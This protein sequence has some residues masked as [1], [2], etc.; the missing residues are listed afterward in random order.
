MYFW[1]LV[2]ISPW[3]RASP[4]ICINLNYLYWRLLCAMFGWNWHVGS[5]EE[6]ENVK[7]LQQRQQQWQRQQQQ[8]RTTNKFWSE[9]LTWAFGL[10][11]LKITVQTT[12][13]HCTFYEKNHFFCFLDFLSGFCTVCLTVCVLGDS[14]GALKLTLE[15]FWDRALPRIPLA[16]FSP[17]FLLDSACDEWGSGLDFL[18]S[19]SCKFSSHSGLR[20]LTMAQ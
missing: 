12:F 19:L 8:R 7:S 5:G 18:M 20:L 4:F 9:N 3:K 10:G 15:D 2:I 14:A 13:D 6:D 11:E 17:R 16:L 1:N